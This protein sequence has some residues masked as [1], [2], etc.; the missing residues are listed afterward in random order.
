MSTI[1]DRFKETSIGSA[2]RIVDFNSILNSSGTFTKLYDLDAIIRSWNT[3]LVTPKRTKDH[4][5]NF[6]SNLHLFIFEPADQGTIDAI[7]DEIE[8]S[9]MSIDDRASITNIDVNFLKN[10]KG[11]SVS[12][13]IS[14]FGERNVLNINFNESLYSY[15]S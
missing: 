5:P 12:I 11:F 2:G 7:K 14:Y 4:D 3:I 10:N 9:V 13:Y 15:Y 6:G 8:N 1:L